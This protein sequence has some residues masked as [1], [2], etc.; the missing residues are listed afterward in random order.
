ML[1]GVEGWWVH[2]VL[3]DGAH[4]GCERLSSC[5]RDLPLGVALRP[6]PRGRRH[7]HVAGSPDLPNI[8]PAIPPYQPAPASGVYADAGR[9]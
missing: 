4:P 3:I 1:E 7:D 2:D 5:L 6:D 9:I 8:V